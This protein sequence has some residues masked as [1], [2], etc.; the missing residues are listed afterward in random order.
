MIHAWL[1][2]YENRKS[3]NEYRAFIQQGEAIAYAE[4]I[5]ADEAP[6]WGIGDEGDETDVYRECHGG[7]VYMYQA[8]DCFT[9]SVE[10][11]KVQEAGESA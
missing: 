8:E 7:N 3:D 1:V 9:V 10:P 4:S 11:L 6:R 2:V 5:V